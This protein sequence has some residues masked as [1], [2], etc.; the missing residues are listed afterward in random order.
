LKQYTA[1]SYTEICKPC[2][3]LFN[4]TQQRADTCRFDGGN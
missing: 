1:C 2:H 3:V 4:E